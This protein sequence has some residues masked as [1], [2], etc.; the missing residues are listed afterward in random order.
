[1]LDV[2]HAEICHSHTASRTSES[3]QPPTS[4]VGDHSASTEKKHHNIHLTFQ[5]TLSL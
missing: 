4:P 2:Q 5:L 1:M 3:A